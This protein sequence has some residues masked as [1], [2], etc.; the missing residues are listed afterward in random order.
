MKKLT[1]GGTQLQHQRLLCLHV[2]NLSE[3][4]KQTHT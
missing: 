1:D 3:N 4:V 2:E